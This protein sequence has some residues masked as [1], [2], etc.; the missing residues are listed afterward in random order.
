MKSLKSPSTTS[1]HVAFKDVKD[2]DVAE[3][4]PKGRQLERSSMLYHSTEKRAE[5]KGIKGLEPLKKLAVSSAP[6]LIPKPL[7]KQITKESLMSHSSYE[8]REALR[9]HALLVSKKVRI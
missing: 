9:K 5:E 7:D 8:P 1:K 3:P 6:A 2:E 4:R